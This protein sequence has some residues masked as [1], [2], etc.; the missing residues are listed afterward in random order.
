MCSTHHSSQRQGPSH[1]LCQCAVS[2]SGSPL[3][4]RCRHA[5]TTSFLP[6]S[7]FSVFLSA[8]LPL[9]LTLFQCLSESLSVSFSECHSLSGVQDARLYFERAIKAFSLAHKIEPTRQNDIE[10]RRQATI[11]KIDTHYTRAAQLNTCCKG[12]PM[13]DARAV[14][15]KSMRV[16]SAI[17]KA[18]D[19]CCNRTRAA[20]ELSKGHSSTGR[21]THW[22][23]HWLTGLLTHWV[24]HPLAYSPTGSLIHWLTHPLAHS[25]T[26]SLTHWLTHSLAH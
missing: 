18:A 7:S 10:N 8:S 22:L 23:I 13:I 14:Q 26:H 20:L 6:L 11:L 3:H 1:C 2:P 15:L 5:G 19:S 4:M 17:S 9:C 12:D 24:T 25:L 21:L 16:P